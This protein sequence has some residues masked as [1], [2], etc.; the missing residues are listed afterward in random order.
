MHPHL[1]KSCTIYASIINKSKHFIIYFNRN[2]SSAGVIQARMPQMQL[3]ICLT[4]WR[5]CYTKHRK[6][7]QALK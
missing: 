1:V 7:S 4:N 6:Y 5:S 2:Q 3:K